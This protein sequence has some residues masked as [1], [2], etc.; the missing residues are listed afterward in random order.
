MWGTP[1]RGLS[2]PCAN[3]A[4][5]PSPNRR[6]SG[7]RRCHGLQFEQIGEQD[8]RLA[9]RT[10]ASKADRACVQIAVSATTLADDA[11]A[12]PRTLVDGMRHERP[13]PLEF[14]AQDVRIDG[15]GQ[16]SPAQTIRQLLACRCAV[17]GAGA[18][19][20]ATA[21]RAGARDKDGARRRVTRSVTQGVRALW[22]AHADCSASS[23]RSTLTRSGGG[24]LCPAST[25]SSSQP[26]SAK[27]S[28]VRA[29]QSWMCRCSV[30][31]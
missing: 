31:I 25:T 4:S 30:R 1:R 28:T 24:K 27:V 9:V 10:T 16:R 8:D 2:K 26:S 18:R 14:L 5:C 19:W 3:R 21:R 6:A 22:S 12:T 11:R 29:R 15:A 7:S 17:N 23:S 13:P 20:R